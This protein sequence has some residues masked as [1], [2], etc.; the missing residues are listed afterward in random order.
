MQEAKQADEQVNQF[1]FVYITTH[2]KKIIPILF[3]SNTI[4]TLQLHLFYSCSSAGRQMAPVFKAI[5][6]QDGYS[7]STK[8]QWHKTTLTTMK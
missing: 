6:G 4:I 8:S 3:C 2:P 7:W 1:K 5:L